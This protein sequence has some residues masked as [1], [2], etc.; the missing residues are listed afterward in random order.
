MEVLESLKG[1]MPEDDGPR[2]TEPSLRFP[3]VFCEH[4]LF[5]VVSCALQMLELPG[6][7]NL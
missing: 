5:S 4:L 3:A 7:R 6:E 1:A 2:V